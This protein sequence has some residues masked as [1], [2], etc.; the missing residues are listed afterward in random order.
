MHIRSYAPFRLMH[1]QE[2]PLPIH[3]GDPQDASS[4]D[5]A[6]EEPAPAPREHRGS[7]VLT[8]IQPWW[9]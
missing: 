9:W 4:E 5:P 6:S 3:L 2:R 1:T 8:A 7:D